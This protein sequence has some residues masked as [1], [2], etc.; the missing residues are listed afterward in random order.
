MHTS[1]AQQCH[2]SI[3]G[4]LSKYTDLLHVENRAENRRL[5]C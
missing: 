3:V 4:A 1:S 5:A 2:A